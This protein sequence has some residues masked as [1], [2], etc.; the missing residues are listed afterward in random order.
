MKKNQKNLYLENDEDLD[1]K[2][3]TYRYLKYWKWIVLSIIL[4]IILGK[5]YLNFTPKKYLSESKILINVGSHD[6]FTLSGLSEISDLSELSKSNINDWIEMLKS[7]RLLSKVIDK[8]DLNVQ[9][10]ENNRF[11]SKQIYKKDANIYIKFVDEKSKYLIDKSVN[12]EVNIFD[13]KK[14]ICKDVDTDIEFEGNF[15]QPVKFPFGNI[16]F[17]R[18]LLSSND[19]KTIISIRPIIDVTL[20]YINSLEVENISKNGNI[21][22]LGM[23]SILPENANNI[24]DLLV[25]QLQEDIK[26]DKNKIGQNTVS[27]INDRLSLI[28]KDLGIT[29]DN[30]EKYKSGKRIFNVETEGI[31]DVQESSRIEEQIKHFSIQLSLIDYMEKFISNNNSSLLPSNIGL[32]DASLISSTQEFNKLILERDNLLKSSTP[33][34]PIVKNLD[35]QIR[36]YNNNLRNSLKNYKNTTSIA[37]KNLQKQM[38]HVSNKITELPSKERGFRDIFRKQQTIEALYL[39]LL[40]KREETEIATASTPN[41]VKV[42]DKAFYYNDPIYPKSSIILLLSSIIGF[43]IPVGI[44]YICFFFDDKVKS[45]KDIE[46]VISN[47]PF[48][49]YVPKAESNVVDIQS[50]NSSSAE[51]F[52]ILRTNINFLLP[53]I[54]FQ[55]K[56]IYITSTI[57]GEGKTFT[58]INL[59]YTLALT[60]KKVLLIEADIRKPKVRENLGI[61]EKLEGIT[62]FLSENIT[63]DDLYSKITSIYYNNE[64]TTTTKIDIL[65]SGK[66]SPNPS[67]LLMNGK[68]SEIIDFGRLHYDYIIVDTAPVGVVTDTLLIN[69]QAD[70]LLYLIRVNYLQKNMLDILVQLQKEGKLNLHKTA[71]LIN[72]VDSKEGY[73]YGQNYKYGY[74]DSKKSWLKKFFKNYI[75]QS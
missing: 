52:R 56:C 61:K 34:N 45:K 59:A 25:L 70:L 43:I 65:P 18:N 55:S 31:K 67:E 11:I 7:R 57:S 54:Q 68:F 44:L 14:F 33:E 39:L 69:N 72:T 64:S 29:D 17:Y 13:N 22:N 12:L 23:Q 19:D 30:M 36:D 63:I 38:G 37:I 51:A 24:I 27:F 4:A 2:E 42:V 28:S 48:I 26:D 20:E 58:A 74:S 60:N 62:D 35:L 46:K 21:I 1:I 49:G 5:V 73:G 41:V 16:I 6:N 53:E 75:S 66:I 8:L 40:K 10:Y 9:Y 32:T 15:G 71:I 50:I 3:L 47:I